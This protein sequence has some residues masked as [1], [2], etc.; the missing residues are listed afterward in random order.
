MLSDREKREMK[1]MAQ[2]EAV[3]KEFEMLEAASRFSPDEPV[4]L[5][6]LLNFLTTM[7]RLC[8]TPPPP[9]PF[10]TYTRILL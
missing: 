3:R 4:N 10:V 7:A 2:S 5:D 8:P 1:E 9:R 6:Q